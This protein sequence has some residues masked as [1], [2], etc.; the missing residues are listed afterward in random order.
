MS[1]AMK[2][3][4]QAEEEATEPGVSIPGEFSLPN[5]FCFNL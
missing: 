4:S 2:K 3:R 1:N 5:F